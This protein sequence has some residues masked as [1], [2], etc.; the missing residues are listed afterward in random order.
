V[1]TADVSVSTGDP[2]ATHLPFRDGV[3]LG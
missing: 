1:R 2:D 3:R